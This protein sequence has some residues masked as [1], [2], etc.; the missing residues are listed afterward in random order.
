MAEATGDPG[1]TGQSLAIQ[2][3]RV[4]SFIE[5]MEADR[6]ACFVLDPNVSGNR[7]RTQPAE[8]E[9]DPSFYDTFTLE[10]TAP[11]D[12][13]IGSR[14]GSIVAVVV[15]GP[16]MCIYGTGF[17]DRRQSLSDYAGLPVALSDART[18]DE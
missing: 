18:G 6:A 13:L 2:V 8:A 12:E 9:A 15:T 7:W 11:V 16:S 1:S 14:T 10:L 4:R 5:L 3:V 17:F